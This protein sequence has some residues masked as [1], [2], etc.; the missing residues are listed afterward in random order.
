MHLMSHSVGFMSS[1]QISSKYA[2]EMWHHFANPKEVTQT[3]C[4]QVPRCGKFPQGLTTQKEIKMYVAKGYNTH[5]NLPT[6][7]TQ[8]ETSCSTLDHQLERRDDLRHQRLTQ[9]WWLSSDKAVVYPEMMREGVSS[10]KRQPTRCY[11][12]RTFR[13]VQAKYIAKTPRKPRT[14]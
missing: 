14:A 6:H 7:E 2:E 1:V 12:L 4:L 9:A 5:I 11:L 3:W 8:R 13:E 10:V